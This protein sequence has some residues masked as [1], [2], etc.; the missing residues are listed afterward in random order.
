MYLPKAKVIEM[1]IIIHQPI[2]VQLPKATFSVQ[3]DCNI[4]HDISAIRKQ[5]RRSLFCYIHWARLEALVF[6]ILDNKPL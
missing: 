1:E 6:A 2:M 4:Y 3:S 5:S